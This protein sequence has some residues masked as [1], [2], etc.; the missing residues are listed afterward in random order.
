MLGVPLMGVLV[1]DQEILL[2][3]IA[4]SIITAL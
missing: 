4:A 1:V 3:M 2:R